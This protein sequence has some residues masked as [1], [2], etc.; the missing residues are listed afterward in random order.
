[1]PILS[2]NKLTDSQISDPAP[3]QFIETWNNMETDW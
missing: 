2:V 1:M 3:D